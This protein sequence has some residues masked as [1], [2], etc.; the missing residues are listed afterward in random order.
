MTEEEWLAST[1]LSALIGY[2]RRRFSNRKARLFAVACCRLVSYLWADEN[3]EPGIEVAGRFAD[4]LASSEERGGAWGLIGV[5]PSFEVRKRDASWWADEAAE[6]AVGGFYPR[7]F[8]KCAA[9]ASREVLE[10]CGETLPMQLRLFRC[11]VGNPFRP[12]SVQKVWRTWNGG[13]AVKIARAIYD[14]RAF[15]LLTVLA[16]ALEDAGCNDADILRHCR[17]PG[18]HVRGCWVVDLLLGK[19]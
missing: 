10:A 18:E 4:G 3:S 7:S 5:S 11:I 16:D 13:T 1:D 15:D 17:E 2:L 19:A 9:I 12:V 8:Y 6:T 14:E